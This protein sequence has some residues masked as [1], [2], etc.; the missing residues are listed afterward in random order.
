MA[1]F[2]SIP[3]IWRLPN[4]L[5]KHISTFLFRDSLL[6]LTQVC[7]L[8]R[9]VAAPEYFALL[10][11]KLPRDTYLPL[12]NNACE[13]LLVWRRTNAFVDLPYI[14]LSVSQATTD[15]HFDALRIFFESLTEV[16]PRVHLFLYTGPYKPTIAFLD[17]LESIRDSGCKELGCHG[18][19]VLGDAPRTYSIDGTPNCKSNLENLEFASSLFFTRMTIGFT[20][21]TL[22][23]APLVKL[24][25]TNTGLT[26]TQWSHFLE[27]LDLRY[28]RELEIEALCPPKSLVQ[29]M[30]RHKVNILAIRPVTITR[31]RPSTSRY[32]RSATP[33]NSLTKLNGSPAYILALLRYAYMPPDTLLHLGVQFQQSDLGISFLSDVLSCTERIPGLDNLFIRIPAG[34]DTRVL[35]LP[36]NDPRTCFVQALSFQIMDDTALVRKLVFLVLSLNRFSVKLCTLVTGF[37]ES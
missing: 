6:V 11:F 15:R 9:E 35:A 10:E 4:E 25:L 1:V 22:Q 24:R 37:P 18:M 23:N 29:F 19:P 16:V 17:L 8:F 28:L 26:G 13:A 14:H 7:K 30:S 5:L 27:N 12:D 20:L 36:E 2:V 21:A 32:S 33:L 3:F 31:L 34:V